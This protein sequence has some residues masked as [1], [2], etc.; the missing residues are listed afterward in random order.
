MKRVLTAVFV[1]CLLVAGNVFALSIPAQ[2]DG[3]VSDYADILLPADVVLLNDKLNQYEKSTTNQIFIAIFPSLEKEDISDFSTRL[4]D[5]W[6]I[7]QK[8]KNNGILIV[9]FIKERQVRIEVGYGLEG[10]V[11]DAVAQQIIQNDMVPSFKTKDY[12]PGFDKATTALMQAIDNSSV[13]PGTA[14]QSE[15]KPDDSVNGWHALFWIVAFVSVLLWKTIHTYKKTTPKLD[16]NLPWWEK[17]LIRI[18]RVFKFLFIFS[19]SF[20]LLIIFIVA[21]AGSGRGG[22]SGGASGGGGR[23]GGGGANGRW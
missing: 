21:L 18:Y 20:I 8:N 19:Y 2:P 5:Q 6:K 16:P 12:Y 9:A 17:V 23:S 4:E 7:G 15:Q 13:V 22:S 10:V 1:F 3:Y 14:L 11:P